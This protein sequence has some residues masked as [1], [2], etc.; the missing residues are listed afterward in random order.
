MFMALL[1]AGV[2]VLLGSLLGLL[3]MGV[4][5]RV[6]GPVRTFAVVSA[7][8]VILGALLPEALEVL[9][10]PAFGLLALGLATPSML[11]KLVGH[12]KNG[13]AGVELG[14]VGLLGHQL[15][16][17]GQIG[18]A[19]TLEA[20][21]FG[22]VLA[23]TAHT[24]P[25]VGAVVL[26]YV[27]HDGRRVALQRVALLLAASCIGAGAGSGLIGALGG[28]EPYLQALLAG[29]LVN[30]LGH[31]L[32][33][34][35]PKN[36]PDKALDLTAAVA[37]AALPMLFLH[38]FGQGHGTNENPGLWM[39]T[40]D[41]LLAIAPWSL[42]GVV[43]ALVGNALIRG[44]P[45]G[46]LRGELYTRVLSGQVGARFW[47]RAG[48]LSL[49]PAL[50]FLGIGLWGWAPT[51]LAVGGL[52]VLGIGGCLLL[53]G[54]K[55]ELGPNR[56]P[57]WFLPWL[58]GGAL[59]AGLLQTSQASGEL[60]LLG[61]LAM[62]PVSAQGMAFAPVASAVGAEAL[63]PSVAVAMLV[64]GPLVLTPPFWK[65]AVSEVGWLRTLG[66]L[67]LGLSC[68]VGIAVAGQAMALEWTPMTARVPMWLR[69][70]SLGSLAAV[71]GL[72]IWDMSTRRWL[73]GWLNH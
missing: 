40:L 39:P 60:G 48:G 68:V 33:A 12:S 29:M 25:L 61:A 13:G 53:G 30:L 67:V 41:V 7:L 51:L 28:F 50:A 24:A 65:Q 10:L 9:G 38:G 2:P 49:S 62:L 37:G 11:G 23:L 36:S 42:A 43:M 5:R 31:D 46:F 72:Q 26:G 1:M 63:R 59:L 20:Q 73:K 8:V 52:M 34:D 55:G 21:G 58:I 35:L 64:A 69:V 18:A 17:G 27:A 15:L 47:L 3:P 70:G 6:L 4:P 32:L 57:L 45:P 19:S 14:F 44:G 71:V 56:G 16:E 66:A 54:P 22:V